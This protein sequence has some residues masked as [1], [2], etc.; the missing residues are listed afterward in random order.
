MKSNI[1][2]RIFLTHKKLP[3][4]YEEV[5]KILVSGTQYIITDFTPYQGIELLIKNVEVYQDENEKQVLFSSSS[6]TSD[7]QVCLLITPVNWLDNVKAYFK[8][9]Q[10]GA[11]PYTYNNISKD[12]TVLLNKNG[13]LY[14][15]NTLQAQSVYQAIVDT[16]LYLFVRSNLTQ[17]ILSGGAGEFGYEKL[18]GTIVQPV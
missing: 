18:D 4:E 8:Y 2:R 7:S 15:N 13:E 3:K 9:F 10:L 17:Y 14:Y 1:R 5:K 12:S 16:P 6:S 11:A